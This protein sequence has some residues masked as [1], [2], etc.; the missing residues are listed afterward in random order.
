MITRR[1]KEVDECLGKKS[2][3]ERIPQQKAPRETLVKTTEI[4]FQSL[5]TSH[6]ALSSRK[7]NQRPWRDCIG[8]N[9][10]KQRWIQELDDTAREG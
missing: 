2:R 6:S 3:K 7:G 1:R 5:V 8:I 9:K 4:S 10:V